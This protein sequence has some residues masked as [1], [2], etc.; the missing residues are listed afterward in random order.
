MRLTGRSAFQLPHTLSFSLSISLLFTV[1]F[2]MPQEI[3]CYWF[4]LSPV[5]EKLLLATTLPPYT[6]T[7]STIQAVTPL[8]VPIKVLYL[9]YAHELLCVVQAVDRRPFS[10]ALSVIA[11]AWG[12]APAQA[13]LGQGFLPSGS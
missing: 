1:L 7:W 10:R 2:I 6:Y 5:V 8:S 4:S 12:L 13:L 11:E 9:K 3:S